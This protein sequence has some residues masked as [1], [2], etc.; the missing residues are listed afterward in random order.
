MQAIKCTQETAE[1]LIERMVPEFRI[2][3]DDDTMVYYEYG[4]HWK[5]IAL[6]YKWAKQMSLF[7]SYMG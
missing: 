6:Y 3:D 1:E 5:P 7:D 4:V 2:R